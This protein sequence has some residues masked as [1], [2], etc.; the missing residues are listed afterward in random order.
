ME[1]GKIGAFTIEAVRELGAK[2]APV[3]LFPEAVPE[4]LAPHRHWL[5]PHFMTPDGRFRFVIRTYVVRTGRSTILVDTCYGNHKQRSSVDVG[6]HMLQTRYIEDLAALGVAPDEVDFVFCTHLHPDHVGWNTRLVDG[7]W[8]PTF[9]KAQYLFGEA[10]WSYFSAVP[11]GGYGTESLLDSVIPVVDAG[12]A[13]FY[14]GT[15]EVETGVVVTPSPGHTPGHSCLRLD[16]AG[17][18]ALIIGDLMHHPIQCAEPSW[19]LMVG[20][21]SPTMDRA[22]CAASRLRCLEDAGES[23]AFM[24]GAHWD[25]PRFGR[26]RPDGGAWRLDL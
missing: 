16:S 17:E 2:V 9:P 4:R 13:R 21:D 10:D 15:Y 23:G 18:R 25:L 8:V 24:F 26:V 14:E 1:P 20:G 19:E 6:G 3:D 7:R 22:A 5:E 12:Q 11:A